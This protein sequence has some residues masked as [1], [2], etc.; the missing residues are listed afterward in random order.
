M[1]LLHYQLIALAFLVPGCIGLFL[2][3]R[4]LS[5]ERLRRID[6]LIAQRRTQGSS[7]RATGMGSYDDG[8]AASIAAAGDGGASCSGG[9]GD[10]G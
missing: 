4:R 9:G 10:C 5:R 3:E 8:G 2:Y 7:S 6:E 1:T